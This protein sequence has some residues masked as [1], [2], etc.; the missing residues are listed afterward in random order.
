[1]MNAKHVGVRTSPCSPWSGTDLRGQMWLSNALA[2]SA[3]MA[4]TCTPTSVVVAVRTHFEVDSNSLLP[5]TRHQ[6]A[7]S[8]SVTVGVR[9]WVASVPCCIDA[10]SNAHPHSRP[11]GT[12]HLHPGAVSGHVRHHVGAH[13]QHDFVQHRRPQVVHEGGALLLRALVVFA[14]QRRLELL[15]LLPALNQLRGALL[16]AQVD[17]RV[18]LLRHQRHLGVHAR[19]P[20]ATQR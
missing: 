7:G 18:E 17:L 9:G 6:N 14:G 4:G 13:Q 5:Q 11:A 8:R 10:S 3:V 12:A 20:N 15:L 2:L 19:L 16:A 1:M